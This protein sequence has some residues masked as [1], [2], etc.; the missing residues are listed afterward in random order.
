M[1]YFFFK[2]QFEP[3]NFKFIKEQFGEFSI[4]K[5]VK[6][7]LYSSLVL[8]KEEAVTLSQMTE[9]KD[10]NLLYRA[11]TDGFEAKAFH[12]KCDGKENT[13][14]IIKTNGNYVFGGYTA[15]KWNSDFGYIS[16]SE[17]FVFSLRRNGKSCNHKFIVSNE[18][19]AIYGNP[20][21]GPSFAYDIVIK[22]KSNG[23]IDS[24]SDLGWAYHYPAENGDSKSFLAGNYDSWLTTEIEVYQINK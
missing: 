11:T 9:S 8:T 22:D 24:F 16:D 7:W 3:S 14:T 15:A 20:N 19:N 2:L 1:F 13:I 12:A 5:K 21:Y 6:S 17:A 23:N 4:E 10:G 18:T